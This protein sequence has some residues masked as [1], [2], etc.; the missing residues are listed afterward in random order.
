MI[1]VYCA[2][3]TSVKVIVGRARCRSRS[4]SSSA[5]RGVRHAD[6]GAAAARQPEVARPDEQQD[7]PEEERRQ[8]PRDQREGQ[9]RHVDTGP[10]PPRRDEPQQ[11]A[12]HDRQHL[13]GQDQPQRVDER[14]AEQVDDGLVAVRVGHA[15]VAAQQLPQVGGELGVER[16]AAVEVEQHRLV[17]PEPHAQRL[18][19]VGAQP[20]VADPRLGGVA[21]QDAEQQEVEGHDDEHGP[22]RP[23]GLARQVAPRPVGRPLA[24]PHVATRLVDRPDDGTSELLSDSAISK[25]SESSQPVNRSLR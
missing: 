22:G 14:P 8:R 1:S 9:G 6:G 12:D 7:D 13:G 15:E 24:R 11:D 23:A 18:D 20:R 25:G 2:S 21:G 16:V 17:E 5:S 19:R 3:S 10:A 4:T